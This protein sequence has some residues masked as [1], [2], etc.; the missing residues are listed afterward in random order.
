[1]PLVR[2]RKARRPRAR[3][4][5][6]LLLGFLLATVT[7]VVVFRWVPPP[8]SMFMAIAGASAWF[9]GDRDFRLQYRWT[10]WDGISPAAKL[11]VVAAEDQLFARHLGFDVKAMQEAFEHNLKAKRLRGGSTI[12]QQTA[13]NLFLYPGRSY[14]RK[15]LEAWFTALIE[16]FW[17]KQRILEV[18]LNVAE[19]GKGIYGVGAAGPAFF[20]KGPEALRPRE[21]ALLAAVL[22]NP[23]LLR[24]DRPSAY[25]KERQAWILG[26]MQRLGGAAYLDDL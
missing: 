6:R 4:L 17:P 21:A 24:A 13:K 9:Q 11:A 15:V 2:S 22:P 16:L 19:F 26:Q 25:V 3:W 18:Y 10:P 12:S 14:V 7:P 5:K 20:G 23:L 8:A 1:V